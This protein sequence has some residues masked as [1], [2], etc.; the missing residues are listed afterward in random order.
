MHESTVRK[1]RLRAKRRQAGWGQFELWLPPDTAA[2]LAQLKQPGEALHH[3]VG[4][5]LRALQ[6]HLSDGTGEHEPC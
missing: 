2:L 4:R 1:R 5:A 3:T 6:A